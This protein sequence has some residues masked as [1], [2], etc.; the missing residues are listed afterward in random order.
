MGADAVVRLKI[1]ETDP[2]TNGE[3]TY[4]GI[5]ASGFAIKRK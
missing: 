1:D 4:R 5:K 3:I 2:V